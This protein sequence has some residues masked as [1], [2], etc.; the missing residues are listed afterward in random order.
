MCRKR[1]E[2][3]SYI[4]PG[5]RATEL[6]FYL[7]SLVPIRSSIPYLLFVKHQQ[8]S[9][10]KAANQIDYGKLINKREKNKPQLSND[11]KADEKVVGLTA[12]QIKKGKSHNFWAVYFEVR[13]KRHPFFIILLGHIYKVNCHIYSYDFQLTITFSEI[14]LHFISL[15]VLI[16][17]MLLLWVYYSLIGRFRFCEVCCCLTNRK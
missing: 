17:K 5:V 15:F 7:K 8:I 16:F 13:H 10:T 3:L 12:A 6:E 9:Q 1:L 4:F 11:K 2:F 14:S